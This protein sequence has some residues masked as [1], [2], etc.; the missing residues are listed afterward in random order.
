MARGIVAL[1]AIGPYL[2]IE[3]IL[4]GGS[5]I[6]LL[7]WLFKHYFARRA[8]LVRSPTDLTKFWTK[9]DFPLLEVGIFELNR[10][11]ENV[12]AEVEQVLKS[13]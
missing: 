3:I 4:P 6:G 12:F 5:L 9:K 13:A 1:R 7:M 2:A 8:T 10:N 11:P